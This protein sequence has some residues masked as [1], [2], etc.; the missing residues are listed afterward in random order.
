MDD[1]EDVTFDLAL[2]AA[3][4]STSLRDRCRDPGVDTDFVLTVDAADGSGRSRIKKIN[5]FLSVCFKE[6]GKQFNVLFLMLPA[7]TEIP[8]NALS[9]Q[10]RLP[11]TACKDISMLT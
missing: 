11:H 5:F 4:T 2:A 6:P 10:C 8:K 3:F 1:P 7:G 9:G